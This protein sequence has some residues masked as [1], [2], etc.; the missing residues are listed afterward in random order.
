M[1]DRSKPQAPLNDRQRH[2]FN[3]LKISRS[4]YEKIGSL[5]KMTGFSLRTTKRDLRRSS[6]AWIDQDRTA[7]ARLGCLWISCGQPVEKRGPKTVPSNAEKRCQNS[8]VKPQKSAANRGST[9]KHPYT[10]TESTYT[11]ESLLD[12][13]VYVDSQQN[14]AAEPAAVPIGR[15]RAASR[16]PPK[17][18]KL[19]PNEQI[20]PMSQQQVDEAWIVRNQSLRSLT[21]PGLRERLRAKWKAQD[22]LALE[23]YEDLVA[24]MATNA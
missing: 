23:M 3:A 12:S 13:E 8:G 19:K 21:S 11:S 2:I 20:D 5:A 7:W 10:T 24:A 14:G 15:R 16:A 17:P 18:D 9:S 1:V 22:R 6:R 4:P